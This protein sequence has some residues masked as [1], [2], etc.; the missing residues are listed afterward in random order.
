MIRIKCPNAKCGKDL[1]VDESKAGA[2][3]ACPNCGQK[4]RIPSAAAKVASKTP[5]KQPVT[6]KESTSKPAAKKPDPNKK[7]WQADDDFDP[8]AVKQEVDDK[9][10]PE[11]DRVDQ[12][13][14]DDWKNKKREKA[15]KEVGIAT[16]LMKIISMVMIGMW[17]LLFTLVSI[18]VIL[19]VFKMEQMAQVPVGG[20]K[21]PDKPEMFIADIYFGARPG[22]APAMLI[23]AIW[24]G[25]LVVALAIY[26]TIIAGS[27]SMKKLE[28]YGLSM[29]SCILAIIFGGGILTIGG[30][31]GLMA[32][33]NENVKLQFPS[34][35]KLRDEKEEEEWAE[36]EEKKRRKRE[37]LPLHDDDEDDDDE[38]RP[39]KKRKKRKKAEASSG[40]SNALILLGSLGAVIVIM[41]V[42]AII[43][44]VMGII[45]F[46][47][48]IILLVIARVWILIIAFT[49]DFLQGILV[50]W[51][52]LYELFYMI[53]RWE[54]CKM[55]LFLALGGFFMMLVGTMFFVFGVVANEAIK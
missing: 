39:R 28:N 26:G 17:L 34:Y 42:L 43:F 36:L 54:E 24:F 29:T 21:A 2:V 25:E 55:T 18:D 20:E 22:E 50:L 37:G 51:I 45:M 35:K 40:M 3:G 49:E 44:P 14:R 10:P 23:W 12:M 4:F 38:D 13:V 53:T 47:G 5:A 11:D 6:A 46:W 7:H 19:Y 27:E 52:P 30:V 9:P 15:W 31:L 32:L 33:Q 16:T 41:A 8:Y 48:G 1:G